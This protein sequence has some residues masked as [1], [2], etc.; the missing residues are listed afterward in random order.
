M[1]ATAVELRQ[2]LGAGGAPFIGGP[3]SA[4]ADADVRLRRPRNSGNRLVAAAA[5]L[6]PGTLSARGSAVARRVINQGWG[7]ESGARGRLCTAT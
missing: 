3:L 4:S 1:P 5:A 6:W 2:S 7:R